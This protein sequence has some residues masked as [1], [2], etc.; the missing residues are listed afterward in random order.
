MRRIDYSN[1]DVFIFLVLTSLLEYDYPHI[2]RQYQQ[3][4]QFNRPALILWGRQD[5]VKPNEIM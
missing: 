3:L 2:E 5:R 1:F 4:R